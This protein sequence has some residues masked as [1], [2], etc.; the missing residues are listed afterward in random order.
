MREHDMASLA[1]RLK[2]TVSI[3]FATKYLHEMPL[4]D[5]ETLQLYT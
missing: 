3:S 4:N 2:F 1:T 5:A